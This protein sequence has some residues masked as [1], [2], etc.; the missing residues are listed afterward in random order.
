MDQPGCRVACMPGPLLKTR[1]Y[2]LGK[3]LETPSIEDI[4]ASRKDKKI[5]N[6]AEYSA[7]DASRRRLRE[8]VTDLRTDGRTDPLIEM[9]GRI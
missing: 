4:S 8:G 9:R 6:K 2:Y 1:A 5:L 3:S 7:L